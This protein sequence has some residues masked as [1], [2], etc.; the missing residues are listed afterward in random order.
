MSLYCFLIKVVWENLIFYTTLNCKV[1]V[2]V[3]IA[4]CVITDIL[5]FSC[6]RTSECQKLSRENCILLQ[7]R[8]H[9]C[10]VQGRTLNI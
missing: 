10:F 1:F 5:Y 6:K 9:D 7:G 3:V 8:S 2:V 4:L